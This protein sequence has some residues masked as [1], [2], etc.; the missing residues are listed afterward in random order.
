MAALFW[1]HQQERA[2]F[3][4]LKI[5]AGVNPSGNS[6]VIAIGAAAPVK[7]PVIGPPVPLN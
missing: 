1:R 7:T 4:D 5:R 3:I 2:S 6:V